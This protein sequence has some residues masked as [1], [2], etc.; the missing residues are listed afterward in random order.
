MRI[1]AEI[2]GQDKL[3]PA[4]KS[5]QESLDDLER[6]THKTNSTMGLL[7]PAMVGV[8]VGGLAAL[9]A[10]F[11]ATVSTAADFEAQMSAV[12]AVSG[13]TG[14]EMQQLSDLA[15]QLGKDTSF[16]ASEA[17]KGLG[18]LVKGGV[19]IPEI[20]SGAAQATLDLAA[21]GGVDLASAATIAANAMSQFNLT[22]SDMGNVVN[23]IAGYAN[24]TTG[25][26][27]D[28]QM[29]LTAVGAV[30]N[31]AGQSFN[32]TAT[33][34]AL[35]ADSG[36][37]GSDAGTSL[38]TMLLN[39]VPNTNASKDA[40]KE[41]GII[42]ADGTNRFIDAQGNYKSLADIAGIL[43]EGISGMGQ[44]QATMALQTA[45]GT[46][47]V[48]AA[49]IMA[50]AGADGFAGMADAMS[51]V[52]AEAVAAERLNNLNGAMQALS[53]SVETAAIT[54]GKAF[55]P[56]ITDLVKGGTQLL[57]DFVIPWAE[58]WAPKIADVAKDVVDGFKAIVE[59]V[60]GTLLPIFGDLS[61]E[62]EEGRRRLED[63]LG[64]LGEWVSSTV[65]P[66]VQTALERLGEAFF[67]WVVVAL[68][69]L[70]EKLLDLGSGVLTF[71]KQQAA[72]FT[73][74]LLSEWVPAFVAWVLG[75]ALPE[76][77]KALGT[78]VVQLIEWLAGGGA[79]QIHEGAQALGLA[80][81]QGTIAGLANMAGQVA[82]WIRTRV[83]P[84]FDQLKTDAFNKAK[85]VGNAM[86]DG[87]IQGIRDKQQQLLDFMKNLATNVLNAAKNVIIARSPSQRFRDEVGLPIA[88]GIIAG[89]QAGRPGVL[90]AAAALVDDAARAATGGL[91][92]ALGGGGGLAPAMPGGGAGVTYITIN[93]GI[94]TDPRQLADAVNRALTQTGNRNG[95]RTP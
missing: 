7:G 18:E 31:L 34:I 3:S 49:A 14:E 66:A 93:A 15:L 71:I 32:D 2:L 10:G 39:L 95:V 17:A 85:E 74:T 68:P 78:A 22:G 19:T 67:N 23:Q 70:R 24:A 83:L 28:F 50:K 27:H 92:V 21:A 33:A 41:L 52:S 86:I 57:N 90:R 76:L 79:Q 65:L 5:A 89:L 77:L 53:G 36:I 91:Q 43:Q 42:M 29:S 58:E 47:A 87:T 61:H 64:D 94:G 60:K 1:V 48:R 38:K 26:V 13:A 63:T 72:P 51:K 69:K 45:F 30:A 44:A 37:K 25:D 75:T 73:Q 35:M 12:S 40:F 59:F 56:A 81:I 16:S 9:G 55:L 4:A 46:D 80:V 84:V 62:S 6:Q 88:A 8:A 11:A 82:D 20:M 54:F